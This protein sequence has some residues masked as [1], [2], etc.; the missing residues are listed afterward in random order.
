MKK[1]DPALQHGHQAVLKH[2]SPEHVE[3]ESC[4][5][6]ALEPRR[7]LT[8]ERAERWISVGKQAEPR[9]WWH[10]LDQHSGTV[11]AD[12]FGRRQDVVFVHLKAL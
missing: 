6:E 10:A 9:W 4:R 5:A 12:V 3:V 2:L 7:G 11:L 1:K 8:S